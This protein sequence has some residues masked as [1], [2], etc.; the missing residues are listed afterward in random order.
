MDSPQ[1][2]KRVTIAQFAVLGGTCVAPK[3]LRFSLVARTV[4]PNH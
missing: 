4:V 2:E 3:T 1:G